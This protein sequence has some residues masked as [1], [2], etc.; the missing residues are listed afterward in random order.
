[1]Q[2]VEKAMNTELFRGRD[3]LSVGESLATGFNPVKRFLANFFELLQLIRTQNRLQFLVRFFS[4]W[5]PVLQAVLTRSATN[6]PAA[7]S[8]TAT[9]AAACS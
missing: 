1:M 7:Q 6:E 4:Y 2:T 9:E 8:K 5:L 3:Y